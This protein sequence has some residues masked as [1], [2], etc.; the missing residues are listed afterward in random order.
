METVLL[1]AASAQRQDGFCL[2]FPPCLLPQ[3][4]EGEENGGMKDTCT[5]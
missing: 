1:I 5:K 3:D 4:R 2:A